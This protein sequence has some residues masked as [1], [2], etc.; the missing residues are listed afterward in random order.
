M[1]KLGCFNI[2]SFHH[3]RKRTGNHFLAGFLRIGGYLR[4]CDVSL[5][6]VAVS[7]R[8]VVREGTDELV[9]EGLDAWILHI[10][11]GLV[12]PIQAGSCPRSGKIEG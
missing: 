4:G 2:A 5:A 9:V 1:I 8:I 7:E 3:R 10:V 12:P 6:P 11:A